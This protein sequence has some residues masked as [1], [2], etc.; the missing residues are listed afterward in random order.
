MGGF[1]I[2]KT[3]LLDLE[4]RSGPEPENVGYPI[5]TPDDDVFVVGTGTPNRF[6]FS[7]VRDGGYG[8]SDIY[9]ISDLKSEPEVA[10]AATRRA[11]D[12]VYG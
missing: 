1:D 2:F 11:T 9:L 7:S 12:T 3:A 5:N 6:Y 4:E 10:K 8:Y